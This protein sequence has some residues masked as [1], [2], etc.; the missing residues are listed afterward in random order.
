MNQ[1]TYTPSPHQYALSVLR[2]INLDLDGI[3]RV[4]DNISAKCGIYKPSYNT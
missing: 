4:V 3:T 2:E 1:F